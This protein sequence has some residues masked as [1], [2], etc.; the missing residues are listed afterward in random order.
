VDGL[1]I[2]HIDATLNDSGTSF[3]HNNSDTAHK[4]IRLMEADGLE[5]IE[6]EPEGGSADS[7]DIYSEGDRF[8]HVTSPSSARYDGT[9][10]CVTVC[11]LIDH[12]FN[13]QISASFSTICSLPP[14]GNAGGPYSA[15]CQG[16]STEITLDGTGSSDPDANDTMNYSW[17]TDI[18]GAD[19]DD[20]TSAT[21]VL[22]ADSSN[23]CSINGTVTVTV[24]DCA[25]NSDSS[26]APVTIQDTL[27]PDIV[28]TLNPSVLWPPQHKMVNIHA[29]VVVTDT[30]N[31][32]AGFV[33]TSI[34][35]NGRITALRWG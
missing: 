27:P 22:I 1:A 7:G 31:Q 10:S 6:A 29:T 34:M 2:W 5:E 12:G 17:T 26:S 9:D 3:R 23:G 32:N 20:P 33:L 28:V 4:L 21:P 13:A 30:C 24:T 8:S 25:G 35:S 18:P 16:A 14:T 11:D 19:F 15:E